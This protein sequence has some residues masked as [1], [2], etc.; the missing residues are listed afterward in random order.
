MGGPTR[1][2]SYK[3]CKLTNRIQNKSFFSCPS[4]DPVRRAIWEENSVVDEAKL[5]TDVFYICEN[6]FKTTDINLDGVR[7]RLRAGTNP[8]KFESGALR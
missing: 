4:K 1:I 7:K 6:H 2:C 3:G 8:V 5:K